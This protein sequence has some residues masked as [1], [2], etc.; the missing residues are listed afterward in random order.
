MAA[1]EPEVRLDIELGDDSVPLLFKA[2]P[3]LAEISR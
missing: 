2:P 3:V 1:E